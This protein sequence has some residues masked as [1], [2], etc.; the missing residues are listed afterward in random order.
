VSPDHASVPPVSTPASTPVS[1][2]DPR[3]IYQSFV[4][5]L[6]SDP[7]H[8]DLLGR[9]TDGH[10]ADEHGWCVSPGHAAH[11][12]RHPCSVV[13]LALLVTGTPVTPLREAAPARPARR[14]ARSA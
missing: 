3:A 12:Q 6:A 2:A 5:E 4:D 13:R 10:A 14:P 7:D 8:G 1:T 11:W 9:M